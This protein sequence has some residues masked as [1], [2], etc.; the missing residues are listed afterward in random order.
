MSAPVAAELPVQSVDVKNIPLRTSANFPPDISRLANAFGSS[1]AIVQ[2]AIFC[3][4]LRRYTEDDVVKIRILR[5]DQTSR[6]GEVIYQT[7]SNEIEVAVDLAH[8]IEKTVEKEAIAASISQI[9]PFRATANGVKPD[10]PERTV[11]YNDSEFLVAVSYRN[12]DQEAFLRD[13]NRSGPLD[14]MCSNFK[15]GIRFRNDRAGDPIHLTYNPTMI[16]FEAANRIAQNLAIFIDSIC[17][18]PIIPLRDHALISSAEEDLVTKHWGAGPTLEI[19]EGAVTHWIE[20]SVRKNPDRVAAVF[21][22]R[23]LTYR[24]LERRSDALARRLVLLGVAKGDLVGLYVNRSLEMV[25]AVVAILKAGAA[26]VPLDPNYPADR[27]QFMVQDAAPLVILT[28]SELEPK[29][30][31]SRGSTLLIDV[32]NEVGEHS[33]AM[34]PVVREEDL[35]YV[36]YTSG[37]TGRPKGVQITHGNVCN[38]LR[39]METEPGLGSDDILVSVTSL[40][41]DIAVLEIFLPLVVGAKIVVVGEDVSADPS[42]LL[43]ALTANKATIMQATPATWRMLASTGGLA[44]IAPLKGLC[45]GEALTADLAQ[46]LIG[47]GVLLWNMYG[48]TETT[49]WSTVARIVD[50]T[51][52]TVGHPIGNT[53]V[54]ILNERMGVVPIG[55]VGELCI[56][57]K[58]VARGYLGRDHLTNERFARVELP[59]GA[60]KRLYRTGDLARFSPSGSIEYLGRAD[61]Q[62]KIRGYRIELGEIEAVLSRVRG[63]AQAV[64]IREGNN[65][66]DMRLAAFLRLRH[67]VTLTLGELRSHLARVLPDHMIPHAFY[68][69]D[70]FPMTP[71][72]KIDR[73]SLRCAPSTRIT[74]T[75]YA[76][77]TTVTESRLV[78]IWKDVLGIDKVGTTDIFNEIGGHSLIALRLLNRIS[79]EF[80]LSLSPSLVFEMPTIEELGRYI[81][82][83][84]NLARTSSGA[85]VSPLDL[86]SAPATF[87]QERIWNTD[88]RNPSDNRFNL[89]FACEVEGQLDIARLERTINRVERTT[90][91]L[92]ANLV[93]GNEGPILVKRKFQYAPIFCRD[94]RGSQLPTARDIAVSRI[95]ADAEEPFW[96]SHGP[97]HRRYLYQTDRDKFILAFVCHHLI[98]D[99]PSEEI[100]WKRITDEY[101]RDQEDGAWTGNSESSP[102]FFQFAIKQRE[103]IG[104][105][106]SDESLRYW[107]EIVPKNS[108]PILMKGSSHPHSTE[109]EYLPADLRFSVSEKLCADLSFANSSRNTGTFVALLAALKLAIYAE[110]DIADLVVGCP[111]S[112]RS[113]TETERMVGLLSDTVLVR[114]SRPTDC[115]ISHFAEE[116]RRACAVAY[117]HQRAPFSYV[118]SMLQPERGMN[119]V[120]T[121]RVRFVYNRPVV[122]ELAVSGVSFRTVAIDTGRVAPQLDLLLYVDHFESRM[123]CKL[124]HNTSLVKSESAGRIVRAFKNFLESYA[125]GPQ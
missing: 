64:V 75:S 49:V 99:A 60:I 116:V 30:P 57:G 65:P 83:T 35:A 36:I 92:L 51:E 90:D 94:T 47:Q 107:K 16:S 28:V 103:S 87:L 15:F 7:S 68:A 48:P 62:V 3:S 95:I 77:P 11:D 84:P 100:L 121:Y 53:E 96:L 55:A 9:R 38:F 45:G 24:E 46:Q 115:D 52:I 97:L 80:N 108:D 61:N 66:E 4:F 73:K 123:D 21:R 27:I 50:V 110:S 85:D 54:Y 102:S 39:S 8:P 33:S 78:D 69:I 23:Q 17:N 25:I 98:V 79:E 117:E 12:E 124:V 104:S 26:Y 112:A 89:I 43:Q 109:E 86:Q 81:D 125:C 63:V 14:R 42:R 71:N 32:I 20:K 118:M 44:S 34:L 58:G 29:A 2:I 114:S 72:G 1:P 119:Y 56:G 122:S 88:S 18:D 67:T 91:A 40:S 31:T 70:S 101:L 113:S 59:D 74:N 37:S 105:P 41:F 93:E 76:A 5:I 22:D 106:A 111:V 19:P 82:R 13:L 10:G 6:H 120:P